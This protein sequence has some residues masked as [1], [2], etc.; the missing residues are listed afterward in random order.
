MFEQDYV[1]RLIHEMVRT[2]IMLLFQRDIRDDEEIIFSKEAKELTE[3]L[4]RLV[5]EGR[6]EE[7][8]NLLVEEMEDGNH[9][10]FEAALMFYEYVNRKDNEFLE[11]NHFS[12][13]EIAEGI[14]YAAR[15]YGYESIVEP[16]LDDIPE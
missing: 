4:R 2:L 15:N 11:S 8:E 16:L 14:G 12:R 6:I 5:D 3:L 10:N 7:A 13:K 1:M 9:M